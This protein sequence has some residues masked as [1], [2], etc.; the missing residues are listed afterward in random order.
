MEVGTLKVVEHV[1]E[2]GRFAALALLTLL[3][4]GETYQFVTVI[5]FRMFRFEI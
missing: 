3:S 2:E 1:A 4:Y 5:R